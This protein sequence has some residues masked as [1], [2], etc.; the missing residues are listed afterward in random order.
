MLLRDVL[1]GILFFS[2]AIG[3][4]MVIA[5]E[6]QTLYGEGLAD[7]SYNASYNK[8]STIQGDAEDIKESVESSDITSGSSASF[9]A[10]GVWDALTLIFT[11]MGLLVS[12]DGILL[13]FARDAG[14]PLWF[15]GS[16]VS[17]IVIIITFVVIS[18]VFR[19]RT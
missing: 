13:S 19:R 10:F 9:F 6:W 16:I 8:L 12:S 17:A 1:L 4:F 18:T 7:S 11:S 14:I 2:I 3:S 15:M 5:T